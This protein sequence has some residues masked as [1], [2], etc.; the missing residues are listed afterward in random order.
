MLAVA[1]V[2]SPFKPPPPSFASMAAAAAA[3]AAA[4]EEARRKETVKAAKRKEKQAAADEKA[5]KLKEEKQNAKAAKAA[6]QRKQ[7]PSPP[8]VAAKDEQR[9]GGDNSGSSSSFFAIGSRVEVT[10]LVS[11]TKLN[12]RA[13][14]VTGYSATSKRHSVKLDNDDSSC[15]DDND[16][17]AERL[18]KARNLKLL[19]AV[20]PPTTFAVGCRVALIGLVS[21]PEA[22]GRHGLVTGYVEATGRYSVLLDKDDGGGGASAAA[23][24]AATD[25]G[26]G[27]S[28]RPENLCL[29][30]QQP[31]I[32]DEYERPLDSGRSGGGGGGS[33][34]SS[35]GG[36]SGRS[37]HLGS[38]TR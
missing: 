16:N 32:S 4:K 37:Y 8:S 6:Q 34:S 3:A 28:I 14:V 30:Q 2:G 11:K 7:N 35:S 20:V 15:D 18:L 38:S 25:T 27:S 12:G 33:S 19:S 1:S 13:G 24:A 26:G 36:R 9:N 5:A 17:N 23:A 21:R 22:N 31:G 10:G 29:V